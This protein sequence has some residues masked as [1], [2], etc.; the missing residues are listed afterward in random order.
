MDY[1][2][3][4]ATIA[5]EYARRRRHHIP[6]T[7]HTVNRLLAAVS[8]LLDQEIVIRERVYVGDIRERV[9]S[10]IDP[11]IGEADTVE[12]V[13]EREGLEAGEVR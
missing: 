7:G 2:E 8:A 3:T 9:Y 4:V 5:R 10:V 6:H 11:G 12:N 1:A 13:G